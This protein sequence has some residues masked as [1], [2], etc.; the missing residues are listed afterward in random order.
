MNVSDSDIMQQSV[1]NGDDDAGVDD[2]VI[3][4]DYQPPDMA[5]MVAKGKSRFYKPYRPRFQKMN[6]STLIDEKKYSEIVQ[7]LQTL[8]HAPSNKQKSK[9]ERDYMK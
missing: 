7:L 3:R 6:N 9:K 1:D 5:T 4:L 2:V 8:K